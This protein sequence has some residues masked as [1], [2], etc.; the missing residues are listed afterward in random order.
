M[1]RSIFCGEEYLNDAEL[2]YYIVVQSISERYSDLES[3]GVRVE[4]INVYEGGGKSVETKQINNIFYKKS[5]IEEFV[6]IIKQG[7]VTPT[8]LYDVVEDYIIETL[9]KA[10]MA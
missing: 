4:K 3:Y 10:K 9:E 7:K 1:E 8:S 5:D 6:R 2:R